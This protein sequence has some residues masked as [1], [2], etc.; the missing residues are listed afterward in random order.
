MHIQ[1]SMW[2]IGCCHV[3]NFFRCLFIFRKNIKQ[4]REWAAISLIFT[5]DNNTACT[6]MLSCYCVRLPI[7]YNKPIVKRKLS[8]GLLHYTLEHDPVRL[9]ASTTPYR[10]S[11][12]RFIGVRS[13]GLRYLVPPSS[14]IVLQWVMTLWYCLSST[15]WCCVH[16]NQMSRIF[17][18]IPSTGW[19]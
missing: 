18:F 5:M 2:R 7:F 16:N 8:D 3:H 19:C 6:C 15:C 11:G 10:W 13:H 14:C 4:L 1:Y 12:V 17:E 9:E